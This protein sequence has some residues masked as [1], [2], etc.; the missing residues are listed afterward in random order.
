MIFFFKVISRERVEISPINSDEPTRKFSTNSAV[1]LFRPLRRQQP[2]NGDVNS[3]GG[4]S[5]SKTVDF[6]IN[7]IGGGEIIEEKAGT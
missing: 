5:V 1:K 7:R 2:G 4:G 6:L 3:P